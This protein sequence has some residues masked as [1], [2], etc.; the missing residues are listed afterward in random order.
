MLLLHSC[1]PG[2]LSAGYYAGVSAPSGFMAMIVPCQLWEI[3]LA[4]TFEMFIT[5][6]AMAILHLPEN[7]TSCLS[8]TLK[9]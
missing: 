7:S 8:I 3:E 5:V 6:N 1:S 2:S 9:R 4:L